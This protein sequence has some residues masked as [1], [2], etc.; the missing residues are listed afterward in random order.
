M[1]LENGSI[2]DSRLE[3]KIGTYVQAHLADW[4]RPR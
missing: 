3:E 1:A 4:S 2:E